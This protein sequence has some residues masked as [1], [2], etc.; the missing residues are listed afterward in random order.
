MLAKDTM[1]S[2]NTSLYP[3]QPA[4]EAWHL[5]RKHRVV[6]LPVKDASGK[7]TGM[8]TRDDI[9]EAGPEVLRKPA[10][11][12]DIMNK[13]VH[14]INEDMPLVNAWALHGQVFP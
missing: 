3:E 14:V 1:T 11:V 6:G 8:V 7:I 2:A 10:T 4:E 5:I 13:F 9:I 12:A